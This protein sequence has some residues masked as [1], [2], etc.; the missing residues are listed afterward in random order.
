MS[1]LGRKDLSDKVHDS[2]KPDSQK[3]LTEQAG[4]K[5]SGAA[6]SVGQS[7]QPNQEKSHS[8]KAADTFSTSAGDKGQQKGDSIVDKT[9]DALGMNK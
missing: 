4:D 8:Q 7:V 6:D 5:L 1:D 2:V 9:K 3:S